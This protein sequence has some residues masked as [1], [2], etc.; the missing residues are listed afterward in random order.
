[1]V[2]TTTH[3][4]G[5]DVHIVQHLTDNR[6]HYSQAVFR[7]LDSAMIAGLLAPFSIMI[8]GEQLPLVQVAEPIPLRVVGNALAFRINTD[9]VND[10]EWREFMASRGIT[11]GQAKA[12][13]VPLSSGGVFAEAVLGRF[14]CAERLLLALAGFACCVA[15]AMPQV[16]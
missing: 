14:N 10:A 15:M 13:V 11:I 9:P 2:H 7:A 4:A 6:L 8:N 1:M 12:E 5:A 16:H 3:A